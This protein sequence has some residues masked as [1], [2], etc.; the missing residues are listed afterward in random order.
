MGGPRGAGRPACPRVVSVC[1]AGLLCACPSLAQAGLGTGRSQVPRVVDSGWDRTGC[2]GGGRAQ[3][4][5]SLV[6]QEARE[7]RPVPHRA[8][9][10]ARHAGGG[11]PLPAAAQGPEPA[12]DRR[13]PGQPAEAVQPRCAR[14]SGLPLPTFPLRTGPRAPPVGRGSH[15]LSPRHT[16]SLGTSSPVQQGQPHPWSRGL[17]AD[18]L[19]CSAGSRPSWGP[20]LLPL[21]PGDGVMVHQAGSPRPCRRRGFQPLAT[22]GSFEKACLHPR[23]S[24]SLS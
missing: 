1:W 4:S 23:P 3:L 12:D 10:R 20:I 6:P 11:G 18:V 15:H 7:G 8:R 21:L 9:L 5:L 19:R 22:A 17:R 14:V 24:P 16:Q 13:V 2:R